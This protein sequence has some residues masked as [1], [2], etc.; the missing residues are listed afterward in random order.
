MAAGEL[1]DD[2]ENDYDDEEALAAAIEPLLLSFGGPDTFDD[3]DAFVAQVRKL[4][5]A[6]TV[7]SSVES[8]SE[9]ESEADEEIA[10]GF[11]DDIERTLGKD[12]N[13]DLV[14]FY[15]QQLQLVIGRLEA[16]NI[17][18]RWLTLEPDQRTEVLSRLVQAMVALGNSQEDP[19]EFFNTHTVILHGS[20]LFGASQDVPGDIDLIISGG[21]SRDVGKKIGI[22]GKLAREP[23]GES[24]SVGSQAGLLDYM[25]GIA[26]SEVGDQ[27]DLADDTAIELP[28]ER[29]TI[30]SITSGPQKARR[31]QVSSGAN[32]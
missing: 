17:G 30:L 31:I 2:Y 9:A 29:V 3:R 27:A 16:G 32:M 26:F 21:Q 8:E 13:P 15:V 19:A 1:F 25:G 12:A 20:Y 4:L 23:E 18:V 11:Q 10:A 6:P 28:M 24:F 22:A 5:P 14:G 7:A